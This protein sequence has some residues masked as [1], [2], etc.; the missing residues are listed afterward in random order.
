MK[1]GVG[2]FIM[3]KLN[4]YSG[5]L[6]TE[7]KSPPL[8]PV[9]SHICKFQSRVLSKVKKIL[10]LSCIAAVFGGV[11]LVNIHL[12]NTVGCHSYK[13]SVFIS[14][15]HQPRWSSSAI[16]DLQ[17]LIIIYKQ[18]I[19]FLLIWLH[20]LALYKYL[21]SQFEKSSIYTLPSES[22]N[23]ILTLQHFKIK[24]RPQF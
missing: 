17:E 22:Q 20:N 7:C 1:D 24:P 23:R 13:N 11:L 4:L 8:V 19:Q 9:L 2:L 14:Y 6:E 12:Q 21:Y 5:S 15:F 3:C 16:Y 10:T 18:I